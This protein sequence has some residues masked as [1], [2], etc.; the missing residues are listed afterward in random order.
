[1]KMKWHVEQGVPGVYLGWA[2]YCVCEPCPTVFTHHRGGCKPCCAGL[3]GVLA[4]GFSAL[5]PESTTSCQRG[6]RNTKGWVQK[7]KAD[8]SE[9][10]DA[11]RERTVNDS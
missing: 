5:T 1:M 10:L 8:K 3:P 4:R 2:Q 11:D 6:G 9:D 7:V